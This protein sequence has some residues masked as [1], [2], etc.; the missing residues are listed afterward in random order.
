MTVIYCITTP[1]TE[2][3][4]WSKT[5]SSGQDATSVMANSERRKLIGFTATCENASESNNTLHVFH[6]SD[7]TLNNIPVEVSELSVTFWPTITPSLHSDTINR[8]NESNFLISHRM[9]SNTT[10]PTITP[11]SK[12]VYKGIKNN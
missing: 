11:T 10:Q 8:S 12:P 9:T 7:E 4:I 3:A 1:K 2:L 6:T 5:G